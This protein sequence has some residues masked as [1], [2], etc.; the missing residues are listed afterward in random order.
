V[1]VVQ[2]LGQLLA[3][4]L[5][6]LALMAEDDRTLEQCLLQLRGQLLHSL[7]AAAPRTIR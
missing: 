6:A 5:V 7:A 3:Q 1:V 4:A 2:E